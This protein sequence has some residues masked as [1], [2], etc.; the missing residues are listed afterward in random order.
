MTTVPD[1][2][3]GRRPGTR[4]RARLR[5][6]AVLGL[7]AAVTLAGC[8]GQ[9]GAAAVVDGRVIAVEDVHTAVAQLSPFF[10][11]ATSENVLA[12]LVQEPTIRAFAQ[13]HGVAVS[14]Q[15]ARAQL[16]DAAAQLEVPTEEFGEPAVSVSRY[17][18]VWEQ[19]T[20][21]PDAQTLIPDLQLELSE[22][23]VEVSPRFGTVDEG[24]ELVAV[25]R[26]WLVTSDDETAVE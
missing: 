6:G 19:L 2:H 11:G 5:T 3:A 22:L 13:E 7:V 24:N 23:D 15:A 21:L 18:L 1:E 17:L 16:T 14:D 26:P 8:T 4:R 9:P 10:E 12:V 20:G 25:D